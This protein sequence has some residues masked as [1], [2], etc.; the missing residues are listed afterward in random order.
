MTEA[1]NIVPLQMQE[2][3]KNARAASRVMAAADTAVKNAALLAAMDAIDS[4]RD[5]LASANARDLEAGTK[6]GLDACYAGSPGA[7]PCQN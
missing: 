7:H 4:T 3:G 1:E 2:L 6:K 5:K